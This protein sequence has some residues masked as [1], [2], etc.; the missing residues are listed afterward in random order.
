V[1]LV[2]PA[3]PTFSGFV[4]KI[5][6]NMDPKHRDRIAFLRVCSGRY[7]QGMRMH[8]VRLGKD[9]KIADAVTFMAGDR[10]RTEEAFPGDVIGLHNHGTIQIGDTFTEG[11]KFKFKGVP[12]FAPEMFR[13]V[14]VRDPLKTKQLER[15]LDQLSEEGASQVFKPLSRNELVVGAVGA[16]QFDLVA[17]RLRDEYRADCVYE[18]AHVHTARWVYCKDAKKLDEFKSKL[19]DYLA[20]DGGGYLTYLAPT[21]ANLQLAQDR[22]PEVEF[23]KT[24]EH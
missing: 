20:V 17:Y 5:Q 6:A 12:N 4:F 2:T 7:T 10:V 14:R 24:R 23:R 16:L 18:D 15:G 22:W 9:V 19:R 1:R 8:H 3:E 13:R 11:E 21:R